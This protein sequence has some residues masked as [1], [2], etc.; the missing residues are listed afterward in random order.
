MQK[1]WLQSR[2]SFRPEKYAARLL[3]RARNPGGGVSAAND[4][5]FRLRIQAFD[6]VCRHDLDLW[7]AFAKFGLSGDADGFPL[8]HGKSLIGRDRKVRRSGV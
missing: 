6:L 8:D 4:S 3:F 5:A 2:N 7:L 1:N